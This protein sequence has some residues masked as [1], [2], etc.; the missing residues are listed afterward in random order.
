VVRLGDEE[1]T[2]VLGRRD[3]LMPHRGLGRRQCG[4]DLLLVALDAL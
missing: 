2:V 1:G 3:R 4:E